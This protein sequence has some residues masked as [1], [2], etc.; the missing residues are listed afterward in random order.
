[1]ELYYTNL[2]LNNGNYRRNLSL[3]R[4][5]EKDRIFCRHDIQ[6]FLNVARITVIL[7]NDRGVEASRDLIYSAALLHDIGR[8]QEQLSG[9]PHHIAGQ[10]TAA[11]ILDEV[12][13]PEEMKQQIIGMIASH[14]SSAPKHNE[15][16][17]IFCEAD[18][19]SRLCLECG[20]E[21]LCNWAGDKKNLDIEV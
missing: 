4:D 3:L 18:K 21:S 15:L 2:I 12:G 10:E 1:M 8:I 20:A 16:E 5:L 17:E 7:C 11:E 9:V 14:R 19:R 13:C 6:H